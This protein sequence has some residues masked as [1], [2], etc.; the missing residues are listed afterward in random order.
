M[1]AETA[2]AKLKRKKHDPR[3]VA[4]AAE[5]ETK[6]GSA[7]GTVA[8]AAGSKRSGQVPE[9]HSVETTVSRRA[10]KNGWAAECTTR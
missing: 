6:G 4:K 3:R 9:R 1:V 2:A 7:V 10:R 5:L 8:K